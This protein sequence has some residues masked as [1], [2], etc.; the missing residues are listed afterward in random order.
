MQIFANVA[1]E[2]EM[3]T[4]KST[5]RGYSQ[6]RVAESQRGTDNQATFYTVRV[7]KEDKPQFKKGD[8]VKI[9]GKLKVDFYLSREGKPTGTLLV[10]AF[11]ASKI[12]KPM[13]QP[14]EVA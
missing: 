3:R 12:S 6:F 13:A 14:V 9:T 10:I 7:M 4:S 5:N 11:D 8:F 1:T 2:P